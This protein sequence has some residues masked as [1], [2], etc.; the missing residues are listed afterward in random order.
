VSEREREQQQQPEWNTS[1]M[2]QKK[3]RH[4]N[5]EGSVKNN[6]KLYIFW[7]TSLT[8]QYK[9]DG[10]NQPKP[11]SAEGCLLPFPSNPKL[12][13]WYVNS[14]SYYTWQFHWRTYDF[15]TSPC[16]PLSLSLVF[17]FFSLFIF[18]LLLIATSTCNN[19]NVAII[20]QNTL[21]MEEWLSNYFFFFRIL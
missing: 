5:N 10:S 3:R 2:L 8:T 14:H 20:T 9:L 13:A 6:H 18:L 11:L 4:N 1:C 16:T 15:I 19:N 7:V 12:C 17:H 21:K